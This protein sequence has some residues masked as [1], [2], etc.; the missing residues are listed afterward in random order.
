[1]GCFQPDVNT[2]S[3]G[4]YHSTDITN[5][6]TKSAFECFELCINYPDCEMFVWHSDLHPGSFILIFLNYTFYFDNLFHFRFMAAS[7]VLA[8][9]RYNAKGYEQRIYWRFHFSKM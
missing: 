7:Y 3:Y 5:E 1:M 6:I 4:P 2:D 9:K 8:E